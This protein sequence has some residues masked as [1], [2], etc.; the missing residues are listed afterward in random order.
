ML[1]YDVGILERGIRGIFA[2]EF[3]TRQRKVKYTRFTS[4]VNSDKEEEKYAMIGTLP[5]LQEL[6]DER[7]LAGFSSFDYTL[8]NKTYRVRFLTLIKRV[9]CERLFRV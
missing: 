4:I 6:I 2:R 9:S 5:Q 8:K 1:P 7:S 3:I